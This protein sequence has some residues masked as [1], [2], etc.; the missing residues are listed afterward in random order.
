MQVGYFGGEQDDWLEMLRANNAS[1]ESKCQ[2]DV[3]ALSQ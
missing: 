3:E 1:E 2:I